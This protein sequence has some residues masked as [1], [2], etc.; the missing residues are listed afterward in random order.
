MNN[1]NPKNPPT[2]H[3]LPVTIALSV[4]DMPD[5]AEIMERT[6]GYVP[7]PGMKTKYVNVIRLLAR[8]FADDRSRPTGKPPPRKLIT[9][10]K[11]EIIAEDE[12][13]P[14]VGPSRSSAKPKPRYNPLRRDRA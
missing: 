3:G 12:P 2:L 5:V 6:I 13:E 4:A 9:V 7:G 14:L 1:Y 8:L 11:T 10:Q